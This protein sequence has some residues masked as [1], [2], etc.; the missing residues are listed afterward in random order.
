MKTFILILV[1]TLAILPGT[2]DGQNRYKASV[3]DLNGSK[4]DK[5][6]IDSLD[7]HFLY[8]SKKENKVKIPYEQIGFIT[9]PKHSGAPNVLVGMLIGAGVGAII[10]LSISIFGETFAAEGL[11][12]GTGAGGALG[13]M[14]IPLRNYNKYNISG[15]STKWV[16]FKEIQEQ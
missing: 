2:L 1:F 15:D 4:I 10:G 3:Y 7:E 9:V 5:V 13:A 16:K 12:I 14:T 6:R 11:L 8:Y